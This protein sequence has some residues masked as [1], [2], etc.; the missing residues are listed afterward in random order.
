MR[1]APKIDLTS[2]ESSVLERWANGR[3][4]PVRLAERA[5]IV[6]L[7]SQ[8]QQDLQIAS[9]LAVTPK[10]AARWRQRFLDLRLKGLEKDAPN[11]KMNTASG[12]VIS[13][14]QQRHRH[15]EWLK[16][17][18]LIDDATPASKDLHLIADNMPRIN[19]PRSSAGSLDIRASMFISRP[20][21]LPGSI[22]W[23]ASSAISPRIASAEASSAACWN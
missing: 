22:W 7:A 12:R 4:T 8:G 21:V 2:D 23:S 20:P 14:C 10:K 15:Q 19:I 6:L 11:E 3:K 16:F 5:R 13:L 17:L 9:E 18:R 1:V